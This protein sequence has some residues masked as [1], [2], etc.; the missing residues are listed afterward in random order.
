MT[1]RESELYE[2]AK[3]RFLLLRE[4]I[5][6]KLADGRLQL[7]EL[8]SLLREFLQGANAILGPLNVTKEERLVVVTNAVLEWWDEDLEKLDLPGP[9]V[10][11][12][13]VIRA[14]LPSIIK[15]LLDWIGV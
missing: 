7:R 15:I 3:A 4:S 12:D 5:K 2:I 8:A 6:E 13:P 11:L 14:A 1:A 9:D 10:V